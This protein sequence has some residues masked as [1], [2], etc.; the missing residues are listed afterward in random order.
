MGLAVVD[1]I[2]NGGCRVGAIWV[3]GVTQLTRVSKI[4]T[5][6]ERKGGSAVL[7]LDF[8]ICALYCQVRDYRNGRKAASDRRTCGIQP[9]WEKAPLTTA[10]LTFIAEVGYVTFWQDMGD[11]ALALELGMTV[12]SP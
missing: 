9:Y 6:S 7:G 8:N 4:E 5:H 3:P 12:Y 1:V 2:F 11:V 10:A